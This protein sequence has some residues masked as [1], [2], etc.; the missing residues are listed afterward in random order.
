[1]MTLKI[2][3]NLRRK[4]APP[5]RARISVAAAARSRSDPTRSDGGAR[6][7]MIPAACHD[8]PRR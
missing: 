2:A 8:R 4:P 3:M 1:M 5:R 6:G 7:S